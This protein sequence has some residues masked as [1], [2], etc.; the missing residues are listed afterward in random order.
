MDHW[1]AGCPIPSLT[2]SVFFALVFSRRHYAIVHCVRMKHYREEIKEKETEAPAGR[3][4]RRQQDE[5]PYWDRTKHPEKA[6]ELVSLINMSQ[7]GNDTKNNSDGI[8]RFAFRRFRR[9]TCPITSVTARG[10][11]RQQMPAVWTRHFISSARLR[12]SRWRIR[13]LHTHFNH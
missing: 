11:F 2:L 10:T 7:A 13:V 12:P 4:E 5:D 8:A 3:C 1:V 9:A 6:R